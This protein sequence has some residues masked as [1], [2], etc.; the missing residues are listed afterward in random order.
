MAFGAPWVFEKKTARLFRSGYLLDVMGVD[1]P[2][3]RGGAH[4][5]WQILHGNR[6]GAVNL[7]VVLGGKETF[8]K[9]PIIKELRYPILRTA[10]EP[11]DYFN[12]CGEKEL[13]FLVSFLHEAKAGKIFAPRELD[14]SKSSYYP[15]LSTVHQGL[16]DWNWGGADIAVCI[17]AFGDPYK[18]ASTYLDGK[19]VFLKGCTALKA[20][21]KSHPFTA[22]I[23]VR[24]NSE[25]VFVAAKGAL[26]RITRILDEKGRDIRAE[27]PLGS[28]FFTPS[29]ELDKAMGFN[30]TY[31][32]SGLTQPPKRKNI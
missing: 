23:V 24:K 5:T 7:Q 10:S 3:Y 9:G 26:L 11:I 2:R 1:L 13:T 6:Q 22:G 12:F 28:R 32:A 30:A 17:G 27:V 20:E 25:G 21:E 29:S 8:H 14:E 19:R 15:F 16:I 31:G 4:Y 18:G